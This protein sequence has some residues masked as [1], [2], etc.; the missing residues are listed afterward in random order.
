MTHKLNLIYYNNRYRMKNID[1]TFPT[2]EENLACDEALMDFCE[3]GMDEEILRFWEPQGH[4]VV[5][6]YSN[7]MDTEVKRLACQKSGIPILRRSSGGG[8]V[9]QG[10]GCLNFSLILKTNG[11]APLKS[12]RDTN[13]FILERHREALEPILKRK[14]EVQGTSD[15]AIGGLKFSGNAQRRKR[16][17]LL[18]HGTFLLDFDIKLVERWLPMPS[19]QPAYRQNRPHGEFL[20]N[21][22]VGPEPIKEALR[23]TWG[24]WEKLDAVPNERIER[25]AGERYSDSDWTAKF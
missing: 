6:G 11:C 12:V 1:L 25:L 10:P 17:F 5:L 21:L 2:P 14:I 24:A 18:Y 22:G 9:L 19:R 16:R 15:L 20:M 7:K 8:A 4:F 23:K 13:R 3:E